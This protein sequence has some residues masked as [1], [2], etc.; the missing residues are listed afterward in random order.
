MVG[1]QFNTFL[2]ILINFIYFYLLYPFLII[3]CSVLPLF[4]VRCT[5]TVYVVGD[6][7]NTILR[8][9]LNFHH[10]NDLSCVDHLYIRA[11]VPLLLEN[12]CF[13]ENCF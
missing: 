12:I 7:K 11:G 13:I 8:N 3:S 5:S 9:K 4:G 2:R 1:F 6:I 10:V